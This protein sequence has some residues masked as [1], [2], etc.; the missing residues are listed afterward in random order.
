MIYLEKMDLAKLNVQTLKSF[1]D[2]MI[3][4]PFHIWMT[5]KKINYLITSISKSLKLLQKKR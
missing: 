3:S 1:F 2:N 5:D 4:F